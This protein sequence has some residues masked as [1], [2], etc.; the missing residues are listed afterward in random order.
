MV[1]SKFQ[2][3]KQSSDSEIK[4]YFIQVL[5]PRED[6]KRAYLFSCYCGL[7]LSDVYALR[8]KDIILDGEQY[9]MSTVMKKT[10]TPIYLP[11][12]RHAIRW[13]PER[14]GEG[15]ESKIFDGLPAE[16]NINKVLAKWVE[17]AKIAKKI[18]YHTSRHTFATMMLTLGADLYTVSKLLGHANVKTTQIYA[19]I[20]DSKKVEAVNLVDSVFD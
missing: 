18:T 15:D 4:A 5:N 2:L 9:R 3:T 13:L 14:N 20:V 1:N 11:L 12:S 19:K 10:V 7:R 8:W 17:T 16:P 6:V